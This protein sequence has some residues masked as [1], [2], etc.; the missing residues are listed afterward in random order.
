ME[1]AEAAL[2]VLDIGL[3]EIARG[4]LLAMALVTLGELGDD[5]F[6]SGALDDLGIETGDEIAEEGDVAPNVACLQDRGADRHVGA[7]QPDA[8]I[9]RTRRMADLQAEIPQ[10]V[11]D[12][13]DD[14][15]AP[16]RLLVGEEEK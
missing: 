15:L 1:I 12:E 7:R 2:A 11:E 5:E 4:A 14:A 13:L 3:D 16:G 9:D 10:R 6:P 8:F